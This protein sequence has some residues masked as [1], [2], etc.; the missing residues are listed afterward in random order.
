MATSHSAT[1]TPALSIQRIDVINGHHRLQA[2]LKVLG[3]ATVTDV[4]TSRSFDVHLVDGEI[5][6]LAP[7]SKS[8]GQSVQAGKS[9]FVHGQ[10]AQSKKNTP[11]YRQLEKRNF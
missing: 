11:F 1:Q 5:V 8:T 4:A 6:E 10:L 3:W 9:K 2:S 7:E